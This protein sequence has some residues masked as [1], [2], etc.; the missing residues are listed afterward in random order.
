MR[1]AFGGSLL[2]SDTGRRVCID[3][4]NTVV[5]DLTDRRDEFAPY[6]NK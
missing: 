4:V 6:Q 3:V 2:Q 5:I 1:C